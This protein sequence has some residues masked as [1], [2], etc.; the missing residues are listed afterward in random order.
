MNR[1]KFA[2]AVNCI[3]GRTQT[4]VID[5]ICSQTSVDYVDMIT[6]AGV[7]KL[8]AD[9]DNALVLKSIRERIRVSVEKHLSRDIWVVAHHDCA[10]NPVNDAVQKKQVH[11]AVELI[12]TWFPQVCVSGLWI[13]EDA[14]PV[15]VSKDSLA[16]P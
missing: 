13:S 1:K 12:R 4:P 11:E 15:Q 6:E 9:R 7:V 2:T 3:D 16:A 10:G 14:Q 8:L 5:Y